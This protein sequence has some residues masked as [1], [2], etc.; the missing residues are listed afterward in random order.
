MK[1][2]TPITY[3]MN[4]LK[5]VG[6]FSIIGGLLAIP[7]FIMFFAL[8]DNINDTISTLEK[9][10]AGA[11]YS[12]LLKNLLQDSQ[13]HRGL[14]VAYLGGNRSYKEQ[15]AV[16]Q[17]E[18]EKDIQEITNF[19]DKAFIKSDHTLTD[20]I[21]KWNEINSTVDSLTVNKAV[22]VQTEYIQL[23]I[24]Y[25]IKIGENSGM[26]LSDSNQQKY[27]AQSTVQTLPLLAERLGQLRA[28]GV[29]VVTAGTVSESQKIELISASS[30]IEESLATLQYELEI[31]MEDQELEQALQQLSMESTQSTI[32]FLEALNQQIIQASRITIGTFE[33]Y[34]LATNTIDKN[35]ELY[36]EVVNQLVTR[37][38]H[39][40][41][42]LKTQRVLM[43]SLTIAILLF[44]TYAFL[45][46]YF[47]IRNNI[48]QLKNSAFKVA[49]GDLTK[50]VSLQTKDEMN[51][52][53]TAFNDMIS[54]LR[55]LIMQINMNAEKVA[56]SSEELT[57]SSEQTTKATEHV[58][59]TIQQI[60]NGADTQMKGINE[61]LIALEE[62]SIGVNRIAEHSSDVAELTIQTALHAEEGTKSVELNVSQMQN[63]YSSVMESNEM[64]KLLYDHSQHIGKI[65]EV[66]KGIADQT[67]L[68]ALNASIEA[69][70]AGDYGKGFAVVAEEVRK[71]AEQSHQ[72]SLQI[73]GL[74][75]GIQGDAEKSVG[76]M[77]EVTKNVESGL[78]I[79]RQTTEKFAQ[80]LHGMNK[81][82]PQI[83]EVSATA[84][85]MS[86]GAEQLVG[87][88]GEIA[89]ISKG[90][91][92]SSEEVVASTEEQ[93]ASMEEI[94]SSA[95]ALTKMAEDLQELVKT[96][97]I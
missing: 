23:L 51:D 25:I 44:V 45:G 79:S 82:A 76:V 12:Q 93:L 15:I 1:L 66:M 41:D 61:S 22:E 70:R 11:E 3:L 53:A 5:F 16:K 94:T 49:D 29:E 95:N 75:Q 56:A 89:N 81:I 36:D 27:L 90:N 80:I 34:Q 47:S 39:D 67:N 71:L 62:I 64:I 42:Q 9:R 43:S 88:V 46:F 26:M 35:F 20:L 40:V 92:S 96:F 48:L 69:A 73:A 7:M 86:A 55:Q 84:E 77:T 57:A 38:N 10:K 17:E 52:I 91:S 21:D 60:S 78:I 59:E 72:S 54:S 58:A 6:K 63:I 24:D 14:S 85:Q 37:V 33:Y 97:K 65:I 2:F 32:Q 19:K 31:M 28:R 8:I 68:L 87:G 83:E 13:Q 18:I 74:V 30:F 50:K 4:R